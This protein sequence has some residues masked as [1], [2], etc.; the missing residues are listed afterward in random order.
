M[1]SNRAVNLAPIR[2]ICVSTNLKT[3]NIN[4]TAVNNNSILC[5][6]PIM[7]QPYSIITYVNSNN[8]KVN[9]FTNTIKTL[10]IK[11]SDQ[12]GQLLDLNG[13]NWTM[14]LQFEIVDYVDNN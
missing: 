14:T 1:T 7:T 8:F 3:N 9:T 12:T 5:S 11:L 6:I 13:A 2:C 4:K 10:S